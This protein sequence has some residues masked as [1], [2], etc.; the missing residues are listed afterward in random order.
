MKKIIKSK[1][2]LEKTERLINLMKS[3]IETLRN[4]NYR[5]YLKYGCPIKSGF[6]NIE[7]NISFSIGINQ[8]NRVNCNILNHDNLG[9]ASNYQ[10][11]LKKIDELC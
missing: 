9:L 1:E 2:V 6:V 4:I 5:Y 3:E 10:N 7:D 8:K 11:I